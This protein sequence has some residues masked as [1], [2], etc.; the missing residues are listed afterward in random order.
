LPL[1]Q[2]TNV[3]GKQL[4]TSVTT[5]Q[6]LSQL[7]NAQK[8]LMLLHAL[9]TNACGKQPQ[10]S[11]TKN[12]LPIQ[13]SQLITAQLPPLLLT[14]LAKKDASSTRTSAEK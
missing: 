14:A 5:S 10:T 4:P 2:L 3:N 9:L 8:A 1:A 6:S 11:A 12:M 7:S 13:L